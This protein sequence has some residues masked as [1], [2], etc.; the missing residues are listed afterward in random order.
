MR[1]KI[2]IDRDQQLIPFLFGYFI[3]YVYIVRWEGYQ[4]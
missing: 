4:I 2:D 1:F 3:N